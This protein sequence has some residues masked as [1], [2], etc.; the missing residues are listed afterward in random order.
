MAALDLAVYGSRAQKTVPLACGL[1]T[2]SLP[3]G[4]SPN[5][6]A[7]FCGGDDNGADLALPYEYYNASDDRSATRVSVE[8]EGR[9]YR[10]RLAAYDVNSVTL[11]S[12][13]DSDVRITVQ[14]YDRSVCERART[15]PHV[16]VE[17]PTDACYATYVLAG[18]SWSAVY[19]LQV[20]AARQQIAQVDL[21][22]RLQNSTGQPQRTERLSVVAGDIAAPLG[23]TVQREIT[24]ESAPAAH[25]QTVAV[26]RAPQS[27]QRAS[28]RM[29]AVPVPAGDF[30]VDDDAT[31]EYDRYTLQ[32]P[33]EIEQGVSQR[34]LL[35]VE[36][37]QMRAQQ[38][39]YVHSLA[40]QRT[41]HE[42]RLQMERY[43]PR[44]VASLFDAQ[45]RYAGSVWWPPSAAGETVLLPLGAPV[46]F[47]ARSDVT[48]TV[49]PEHQTSNNTRAAVQA[50]P[51]ERVRVQTR[52]RV[53]VQNRTR[54]EALLVLQAPRPTVPY[55]ASIAPTQETRE[56]L[57]EWHL[58][59]PDGATQWQATLETLEP[60][61]DLQ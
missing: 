9:T 5:A 7:C 29:S 27:A 18:L 48:R 20:D 37:S 60:A 46:R 19:V 50:R 54:D 21:Y 30:Q 24:Q 2:L 56:H 59:V 17:A 1:N 6:V 14:D 41:W 58:R 52:I 10:G 35:R 39:V 15:R 8:K 57:L 40:Q 13:D 55:R 43:T 53:R 36:A 47:T 25:V 26:T 22:A 3:D 12:D 44:G 33:L 51:D 11:V 61:A 45:H 42:Y 49:L 34:L 23:D 28:A 38:H 32:G 31:R 4:V 16:Q